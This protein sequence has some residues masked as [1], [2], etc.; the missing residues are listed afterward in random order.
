MIYILNLL[1]GEREIAYYYA[2]YS[3]GGILYKKGRGGSKKL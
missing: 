3:Q 2:F 1:R